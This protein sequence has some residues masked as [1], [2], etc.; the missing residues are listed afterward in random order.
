MRLNT[1]S[2]ILTILGLNVLLLVTPLAWWAHF[3]GRLNDNIVFARKFPTECSINNADF[4]C[5][6]LYGDRST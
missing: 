3:D 1:R 5:S 6:L 2:S 4:P